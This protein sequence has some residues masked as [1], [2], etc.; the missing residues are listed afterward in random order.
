MTFASDRSR[1]TFS[2][3]W[4]QRTCAQL[5][6]DV[7]C[8]PT[9]ASLYGPTRIASHDCA[10]VGHARLAPQPF[11]HRLLLRQP[12]P[13]GAVALNTRNRRH[14]TL[15]SDSAARASEHRCARVR[16]TFQ[17]VR[18]L[19]T[20]L[21]DR[22]SG[23]TEQSAELPRLRHRSTRLCLARSSGFQVRAPRGRSNSIPDSAP[24]PSRV[25]LH[26]LASA[27]PMGASGAGSLMARCPDW[28][29]DSFSPSWR[30]SA[31]MLWSI[32]PC[33]RRGPSST[34]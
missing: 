29:C 32:R 5:R 6:P 27:P 10:A 16:R 3:R 4:Y 7:K 1:R 26:T 17:A 33:K 28:R 34:R 31:F 20:T 21:R 22:R 15:R 19:S 11:S 23:F 9:G 30:A 18:N 24:A 12:H 8:W 2:G 25:S 13:E 14:A